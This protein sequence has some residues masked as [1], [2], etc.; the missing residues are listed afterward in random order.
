MNKRIRV[1]SRRLKHVARIVILSLVYQ[2]VYPNVSM[3]LTSG[4]SQP[5]V[6]SFEPVGTTDMVDLFTGDFVYNIPLLDIEGYPINISYH[7]GVGME[8]EASWCGLG[9]NINPGV[10]NRAVRGI[11]DDFR[12]DTLAKE[13]NIKEEK[14]IRIGMGG[15]GELVGIGDPIF[16][17]S[18][19]V[20]GNVNI[21]NYRGVGVDFSFG[22]GVNLFRCVSAGINM[23]VGSQ[24]GAE[25]DYNAG[26]QLSSAQT[27]SKDVAGGIGVSYGHGYSSR[28]G[29]KDASFTISSSLTAGNVRMSGPTMG[30][31]IPIGIQN[32]VPVITNKSS[33][34]TINA[35]IKLGVEA[36]WC[37]GFGNIKLMSSNLKF[38]S[39]GSRR[40]YGYLYYQDASTTNKVDILDFT[41][42]RD[43]MFNKSMQYLPPGNM[44]YDVY[45]VNG[46]GTGGSFRPFRNDLGSV[47]DPVIVSDD[48]NSH[49]G[50]AEASL[51]WL[52]GAGGD[53]SYSHTDIKS[54]PWGPYTKPFVQ[55]AS[56]SLSEN[57]YF[58]QGGELSS[59][60]TYYFN[61]L[62][63]LNPI[64]G[65]ATEELS[66]KSGREPRANLLHYFDGDEASEYGVASSVNINSYSIDS[67]GNGPIVPQE[68]FPRAESGKFKRKGYHLS[69]LVQL[70]TDGKRFVYGIPA[71]NNVQKE[72]TF[73]VS[74]PSG[75]DLAK[76]LVPYS[77]GQDSKNNTT[78]RDHYFSSTITPAFAHSYLLTSVLSPGYTDVTG[79]G[80]S[81]DDLGSYTKFN[82]TRKENDYRWRA[83]IET[84]KAQYNPGYW[85]DSEDD[86]ANYII[87]SREQWILHSVESKNFI[88]EFYTSERN[89]AKGVKN[90]IP[91]ATGYDTELS[92]AGSSYKLDSIKLYNKHDRFANGGNAIPVKTVIFKY[93]Y[94]L[95]PGVPNGADSSTGKLTLRK[96]FV[97]YGNSDKS[98]QSPYQFEYYDGEENPSYSLADKDRWGNYKPNNASL[99]NYEFPF[100]K[101]DSIT[102]SYA[103]AWSLKKIQLPS[104]GVIEVD[105]ESDDYAYVQD[106]PAM[107]MFMVEGIGNSRNF[108]P[109]TQLFADKNSPNLYIYF[110][111]RF[112]D[113]GYADIASKYLRGS[114]TV[115]Y[116]F[117]IDLRGDRYEQIKGYGEV[118]SIGVCSDEAYGYIELKSVTPKGGGATAHPAT[119]TALNFGRYNLPQILFPGSDPNMSG[120]QNILAGMKEAVME[121][122]SLGKNPI[123]RLIREGRAKEVNLVK[124]YVRLNSPDMKKK[125]GGQRVKSLKF[126]DSWAE[127]AKGDNVSADYGKNY[128]YTLTQSG[129]GQISSGVASYEPMIGGD[130]NP[131][132]N[133]VKFT[134]QSGSKFPPT[135]PVELYQETPIAESLFPSPNVGYS[136]VT[137]TSIHKAQGRSAQGIDVY[138]FYTS[139]D[140]PFQVLNTALDKLKDENDFSLF[141]QKNILEASQGYTIILNDMHGKPKSTEHYVWLPKGGNA[142]PVSWTNY[143]YFESNGKLNNNVNVL[144]YDGTKI[145]KT[146]MQLGVEMDMTIDTR[147]K[148][149]H[150]KNDN[151]NVN[152]NATNV[153][154]VLIPIPFPFPWEGRYKNEF[155]SVVATKVVQ[156]YGIMKEVKNF[157]E[158]T[159][160]IVRNEA[161]DPH[162]GQALITSVNNE[163]Q[164]I[165]YNVN[166][167][168]YWGYK[169]MGPAYVNIGY[170]DDFDK[171]PIYGYQ[172]SLPAGNRNV[173]YRIGDELLVTYKR[174]D[175]SF[176]ANVWVMGFEGGDIADCCRPIVAPRYPDQTPG[177]GLGPT[178][179]DTITDVRIKIVRSGCKN[180]LGESIQNYSTLAEPFTSV[181][182]LRDT[183]SDL[184]AIKASLYS[185][186]FTR[187]L[188]TQ[189]SSTT[190]NAFVKG[191]KGLYRLVQEYTYLKNRTYNGTATRKAGLFSALSL[192]LPIGVYKNF[193]APPIL[194][195]A[196][197][198]AGNNRLIAQYLLPDGNLIDDK[199]KFVRSVTAFSPFGQELEN[200]DAVGN[201]STAVYG[202]N[203]DLPVALAFNARQGEVLAEGF[204]D[205]SVL[206]YAN[207][208]M[209]FA[210]S[211][212]KNLFSVQ[213]L[214]NSSYSLFNLANGQGGLSI[215][216]ATAHTGLYS[217]KT[218][219][220]ATIQIPVSSSNL[221]YNPS[222]L[223]PAKMYLL[224]YW[225]RPTSVTGLETAYPSPGSP[226]F[227]G[228]ASFPASYTTNL[229]EQWQ[230]V[231]CVFRSDT[232]GV[233]NFTIPANH[234][235]DDIRICPIDGNMK[236]FVYHPVNEK[237]I[238]TLDENNFA[239]FFEYDQEGNL[240]RTKKET[241]KGILTLSESRSANPKIQ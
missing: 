132:R 66:G 234:Y 220:T 230:K 54:G 209:Q 195:T 106:K 85:S 171:V 5:E 182:Y 210:Y 16:G 88:G 223:K 211:P 169:C 139:K 191:E 212:F 205:Y 238:A 152:V 86:K 176:K 154:F 7:G 8:Q 197:C 214:G 92:S 116:N 37:N 186:S 84:G 24:T 217:L 43:G 138:Q 183:L 155:R 103:R 198:N 196:D 137:V 117:N 101:Q 73:S 93:N 18:A 130:E 224:S 192:W 61:Y 142:K 35:R 185:D 50:Q 127:Q 29:L 226:V 64:T 135:D 72:A 111:R 125:G 83:P 90:P 109:G 1:H 53:A 219:S 159:V 99:T 161:F 134:V 95:C 213:T 200:K 221:I 77:S 41:R 34:L 120:L 69:E 59:V 100:V 45:A 121:L 9:W 4:P 146:T 190:L 202:Y 203:E 52:F 44:T 178:S 20:G 179:S 122:L 129:H 124:S 162:T 123:V 98:L 57:V 15:G 2:T 6:Q 31:T 225:I 107:E 163:Y 67:F 81:D 47:Y 33:M 119:Y 113:T 108:M 145:K 80:P 74:A 104:G 112:P 218:T 38:D 128:D 36:A 189:N 241:E 188:P 68:S 51:G 78:G 199:W 165:E 133:P 170:E 10:I 235:I 187:N 87:G 140:Y 149:E 79:N 3:A 32:F 49:S 216:N 70:Q 131:F 147:E 222:V 114:N 174:N 25:I 65:V 105:Y 167:P 89:D 55:N 150:T 215:V 71:M 12:G 118:Q 206:Q 48:N 58:K 184:I 144:A 75:T 233:V 13:L 207:N 156:Q 136:Y 30:G 82:Y 19:E 11:P 76:G 148:T 240:V 94:S 62:G 239:T 160:T 27:V 181:G 39:D 56:R 201:F 157:N 194:N 91:G 177:W 173:N 126:Y 21:S 153:L 180:L 42:D 110:K 46:Q 227:Y 14:T 193:C 17:L 26:L 175:S 151:L 23:G 236:A 158:G 231:E 204:E 143:K 60:S 164:D 102:D 96:I 166:Y 208:M 28:T 115:Y 141:E 172:A 237:L 168:A 97:R 232:A 40:S 228:N 229:I 22:V 63:G